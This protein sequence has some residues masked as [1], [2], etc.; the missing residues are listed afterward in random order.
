MMSLLSLT[1]KP[2]AHVTSFFAEPATYTVYV[3]VY[4]FNE[5]IVRCNVELSKCCLDVEIGN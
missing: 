1:M 4:F 2:S 5:L 3:T